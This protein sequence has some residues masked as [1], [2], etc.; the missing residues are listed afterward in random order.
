MNGKQWWVAVGLA[1]GW[2]PVVAAGSVP[3]ALV[4]VVAG[5]KSEA[6]KARDKAEKK[7]AAFVKEYDPAHRLANK[8]AEL[9]KDVAALDKELE[10]LAAVD[11]AAGAELKAKRD[12]AVA[13]A[14]QAVGSAASDKATG[15]LD[16]KL[17]KLAKDFDG[18]KKNLANVDAKAVERARKELDAL[19]D[20]LEGDTKKQYEAKRDELF[21]KLESGV[22]DAKVKILRNGTEAAPVVAAAPGIEPI[23]PMKPTWCEGVVE[24]VGKKIDS[25]RLTPPRD[26]DGAPARTILFSCLDAD[27]DVRQQVMAQYRQAM[28][29]A[30]GLTAATNERLMKLAGKQFLNDDPNPHVSL[31]S[32]ELVPLKEGTALELAGSRLERAA[33]GCSNKGGEGGPRLIDVDTAA[34][35][36]TQLARAGLVRV[37]LGAGEGGPPSDAQ[38]LASASDVAVLSTVAFDDA[39]FEKELEGMKLSPFG[40]AQALVGYYGGRRRLADAQR[41]L[42]EKAKKLPG[43]SKLVFD[44]PSAAAKA[45]VA[46]RAPKDKPLLD[47]VLAMEAQPGNLKGCG[48]KVAPFI[49]AELA[50][51]GKAKLEEVEFSG[52]LAWAA[53][54]C[55]RR[56]PDAPVME[57]VFTY[58]AERST[59]VRGPLTAA[60]LAYV[61]AYNDVA[62]G[63]QQQ[64]FD[65]GRRTK[66]GGGDSAYPQPRR[67]PIGEAQLS[68]SIFGHMNSLNPTGPL[69]S[70]VVKA[71][72]KKGDFAQITFKTEKFMVPDLSCVETNKIDRIASDGTILYRS[73]CKKVGEHEESSTPDPV[74]VP[75][76]AAVGAAPGH[77]LVLY[78]SPVNS[79]AAGSGWILEAFDSKA[80]KSRVG[81]LGLAP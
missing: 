37:V 66:G 11:A 67:N 7:L 51:Q 10:A 6:E 64:G 2:T 56:D 44:A 38:T 30:L 57:A 71:V 14:Q 22:A 68:D 17:E 28:S 36:P 19:I 74:K 50:R 42:R 75:A 40:Q 35:P 26:W 24:S 15:D 20:K 61:D 62:A 79:E 31:C 23:A 54:E 43:L 77:A 60:Y 72:E 70:A 16:K 48:K 12:Q 33:L 18:D 65:E 53:A 76:W 58:Y 3:S 34:G 4:G 81:L 41:V 73:L 69:G 9:E 49:T 32:K 80:R 21:G 8:S 27:W 1:A 47:L 5:A 25:L 52:L 13:A 78:W 45:Y 39:A 63:V 59:A 55:G 46:E 29:N